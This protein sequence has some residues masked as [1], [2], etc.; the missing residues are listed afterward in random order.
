MGHGAH[1]PSV[2]LQDQ[3]VADCPTPTFD[4]SHST[5]GWETPAKRDPPWLEACE[6][7]RVKSDGSFQQEGD[8]S[9][10]QNMPRRRRPHQ[11]FWTGIFL[12]LPPLRNDPPRVWPASK[13]TK[14]KDDP[15]TSN[16]PGN[17]LG[18]GLGR[19]WSRC[20]SKGGFGP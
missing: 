6:P 9:F 5:D 1:L 15:P 12:P 3:L 20:P 14:L 8:S 17:S 10:A 19:V 2:L 4:A 7:T 11:A 18:T 13:K 16:D